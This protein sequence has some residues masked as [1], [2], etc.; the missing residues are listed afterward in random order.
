MKIL[1]VALLLIIMAVATGAWAQSAT[2]SGL[3]GD[4]TLITKGSGLLYGVLIV[5]D[6][7]NNGAIVVYDNDT[8][9]ASGTILFKAT[10]PGASYF[11]GGT[12]EIPVRFSKGVYVDMTGTGMGYIIYYRKE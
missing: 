3:V 9:A 6:G 4:D 10:V 12:W 8:S 2:S 1:A 11:G 7:S 5:T